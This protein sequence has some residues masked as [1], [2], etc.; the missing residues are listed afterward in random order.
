MAQPVAAYAAQLRRRDPQ[1][2]RIELDWP[3]LANMRAD[4]FAQPFDLGCAPVI[5]RRAGCRYDIGQTC[6]LYKKC[7][8]QV[9]AASGVYL[10]MRGVPVDESSSNTTVAAIAVK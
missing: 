1:F 5:D 3:M 2:S 7:N 4:Q 8:H 9:I 10:M 6:D